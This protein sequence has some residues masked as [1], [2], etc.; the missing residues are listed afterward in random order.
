M[1]IGII[2]ILKTGCAY[3]PLDLKLPEERIKFILKD[4]AI[5]FI[6]TQSSL[7]TQLYHVS[8]SIHQVAIDQAPYYLEQTNKV[9][10]STLS[11]HLF[12]ILYTSGTTGQSKGVMLCHSNVLQLFKQ[13]EQN[14]WFGPASIW[15]M[16]HSYAFD[17]SIWE[18]WGALLYGGKL[19]I[20]AE[21]ETQNIGV[22]YD[23]C[24]KYRVSIFSQTPLVF[25]KFIQE[26]LY[27][28]RTL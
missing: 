1:I 11:Q 8:S 7:C 27:R 5:E 15:T 24:E 26:A 19:I 21:D 10:Q 14:N 25:Y 13:I 16:F 18:M 17:F 12:S 4:S 22:F 28:P 6:L 2:S 20:P 9:T 3:L 23:L